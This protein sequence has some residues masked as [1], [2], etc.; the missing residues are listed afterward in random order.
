MEYMFGDLDVFVGWFSMF[1]IYCNDC[2][3]RIDDLEFLLSL[4]FMGVDENFFKFL[5]L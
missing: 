4:W 3:F 2:I 5:L 1:V